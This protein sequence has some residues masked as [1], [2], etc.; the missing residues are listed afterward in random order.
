[1]SEKIMSVKEFS[2]KN[3]VD[4]KSFLAIVNH[5]SK[6]KPIYEK[7]TLKLYRVVDLKELLSKYKQ[8]TA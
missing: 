6:Y 4:Y 7:A 2:D 1:M 8:L 5:S 3:K